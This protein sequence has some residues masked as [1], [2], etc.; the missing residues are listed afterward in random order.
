MK[1]RHPFRVTLGDHKNAWLKLKPSWK[2]TSQQI[3]KTLKSGC[4]HHQLHSSAHLS[5]VIRRG[6]KR[7]M[8]RKHAPQRWAAKAPGVAIASHVG[9]S[10][11]YTI[12]SK[13]WL[14]GVIVLRKHC[15]KML[16]DL[17]SKNS[18]G[19]KVD[20]ASLLSRPAFPPLPLRPAMI[21]PLSC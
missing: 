20:T 6:E 10:W 3:T 13:I 2:T 1:S 5:H 15:V 7:N 14:H 9:C 18:T 4:N 12:S 17:T 11:G 8:Q 19:I 16:D 21:A